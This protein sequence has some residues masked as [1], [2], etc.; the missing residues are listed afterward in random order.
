MKLFFAMLFLTIGL[1]ASPTQV[2]V[3]LVGIGDG[4]TTYIGPNDVYVSPYTLQINGVDYVA[5]C[6]DALDES[7][8]NSPWIADIDVLPNISNT[9]H[10]SSLTNYEEEVYLYNQITASGVSATSQTA[11]QLAAWSIFDPTILGSLP[12]S[13]TKTEAYTDVILAQSFVSD[14]LPGVNLSNYQIVS[15]PEGQVEQQEFII[16][17]VPVSNVPETSTLFMLGTGLFM[18]SYGRQKIGKG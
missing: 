1:F 9:Y 3:D 2:S 18:I 8:E 14:R 5:L 4:V 10:P 13:T 17:G 12:N 6:I 11:L 16:D 15:S 7:A